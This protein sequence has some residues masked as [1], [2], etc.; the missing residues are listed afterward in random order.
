MHAQINKFPDSFAVA[1]S[2]KGIKD[3]ILLKFP[4]FSCLRLF[5]ARGLLEVIGVLKEAYYT[6]NGLF[7]I[8]PLGKGRPITIATALLKLYCWQIVVAHL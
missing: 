6:I 1:Q 7:G 2:G 4:G 3:A 5:E 8:L